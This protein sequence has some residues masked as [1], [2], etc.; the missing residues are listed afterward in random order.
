MS[1]RAPPAA[2]ELRDVIQLL[3]EVVV[4]FE[5]QHSQE[6]QALRAENESLAAE[7]RELRRQAAA[8]QR[9]LTLKGPGAVGEPA[10]GSNWMAWMPGGS[11]V[12]LT[13]KSNRLASALWR[14]A[15][16]YLASGFVELTKNQGITKSAGQTSGAILA[17]WSW[18]PDPGGLK[19]HASGASQPGPGTIASAHLQYPV[20]AGQERGDEEFEDDTS[21][22]QKREET[23]QNAEWFSSWSHSQEQLVSPSR[24]KAWQS[25]NASELGV[26]GT[27]DRLKRARQIIHSG[28]PEAQ[29]DP[30]EASRGLAA[31]PASPLVQPPKQKGVRDIRSTLADQAALQAQLSEMQRYMSHVHERF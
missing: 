3:N 30:L 28:G 18:R 22:L 8:A 7:T 23:Q 1:S 2:N 31:S 9:A 6:L 24:L 16:R 13:E 26:S 21:R 20:N 10:P 11:R 15:R 19:P 25:A 5:D 14:V 4:R 27:L 29:E 17:T 12:P